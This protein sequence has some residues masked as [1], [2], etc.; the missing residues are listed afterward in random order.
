MDQLTQRKI[1]QLFTALL[2]KTDRNEPNEPSPTHY[3]QN[4][5]DLLRQRWWWWWWWWCTWI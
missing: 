3:Q 2:H 4:S 1:E 5:P